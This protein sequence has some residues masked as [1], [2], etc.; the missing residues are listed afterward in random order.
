MQVRWPCLKFKYGVG[1]NKFNYASFN[2]FLPS[3]PFFINYCLIFLFSILL[4]W[5]KINTI[6]NNDNTT[7][8]TH[9]AILQKNQN[10]QLAATVARAAIR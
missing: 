9:A 4:F 3:A 8:S 6:N 2:V 5:T 1:R 10:L 7:P